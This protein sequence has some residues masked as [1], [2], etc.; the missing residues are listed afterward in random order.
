MCID[1]A[2]IKIHKWAWYFALADQTKMDGKSSTCLKRKSS[3][4]Q[5]SLILTK[6]WQCYII[7]DFSNLKQIHLRKEKQLKPMSAISWEFGNTPPQYPHPPQH[8]SIWNKPQNPPYIDQNRILLHFWFQPTS[9][10][11]WHKSKIIHMLNSTRIYIAFPQSKKNTNEWIVK[12]RSKEDPSHKTSIKWQIQDHW[13]RG[14]ETTYLETSRK[15]DWSGKG[16]NFGAVDGVNW[17]EGVK[18]T[19]R[20]R[21]KCET[22]VFF[23][24][25]GREGDM[26]IYNV[27]GGI[28]YTRSKEE[29]LFHKSLPYNAHWVGISFSPVAWRKSLQNT[30]GV[31]NSCA[32][33]IY[34]RLNRTRRRCPVRPFR[35][36]VEIYITVRRKQ[37]IIIIIRRDSL[38]ES[39]FKKSDSG[40]DSFRASPSRLAESHGTLPSRAES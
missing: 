13:E 5:C 31:H 20:K 10:K 8:R 23:H 14:S 18:D 28:Y 24:S 30:A 9:L 33:A 21:W 16:C 2:P 11:R 35:W 17:W 27:N 19:E 7:T 37:L 32:G 6:P 29:T 12:G 3:R 26:K 1:I 36:P 34:R 39:R 4:H 38:V 25:I 22:F 40:P 15:W